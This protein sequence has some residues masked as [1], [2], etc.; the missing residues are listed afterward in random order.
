M[1]IDKCTAFSYWF[2]HF[3]VEMLCFF[4]LESLFSGASLLNII[5]LFA[6]D[7]IAFLTQPFLGK[8]FE[9][10]Q[11]LRPGLIG[12]ALLIFGSTF[13]LIFRDNYPVCI[14]GLVIFTLGNA[15]VHISGALAT[16]RVS[17][18][19]LSESAIFVSGGSFGLISGKMLAKYY[20]PAF[21]AFIPALL[22]LLVLYF[23]DKRIRANYKDTAYDFI[24]YPLKHNITTAK[25]AAA[26]VVVLTLIVVGR[27]YIGYG[28][29]TAWNTSNIQTVLLFVFM[30][31][32][33]MLGGVLADRFGARTVGIT[34]CLLSLPILLVSNHIMWLSLLGIAMFSMTMSI[35]LGGLFS[36]FRKSPGLAF[37]L[38]TIGLFFGSA[39]LF[40]TPMPPRLICNLLNLFLSLAA[41][42]GIYYCITNRKNGGSSHSC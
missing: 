17:E 35:T 39:P 29:P 32:G 26:I 1:K 37:G 8:F 9:H 38:T 19:K 11:K 6:F 31:L 28:L 41:A 15:I 13:S 7:A 4:V 34:A 3:S 25:P 42:A 5:A 12:D 36:V 2:A 27:G 30:G 16:A 33:K 23:V 14:T 21:V 20:V 24:H 22:S 18:G 40:C 10:Y